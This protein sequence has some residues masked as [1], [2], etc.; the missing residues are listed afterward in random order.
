MGSYHLLPVAG[1]PYLDPKEVVRRLSAEFDHCNAV[2][3]PREGSYD[4]SIADAEAAPNRL[5]FRV[6]ANEGLLINYDSS[7]QDLETCLLRKRCATVLGYESI[8]L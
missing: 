4:V 5:T 2:P 3:S 8:R 7:A 1:Q 6:R